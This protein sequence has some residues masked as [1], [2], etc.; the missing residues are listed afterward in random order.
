MAKTR[1]RHKPLTGQNQVSVKKKH[2]LLISILEI[3]HNADISKKTMPMSMLGH[4]KED[5]CV[6]KSPWNDSYI[7]IGPLWSG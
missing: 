7:I 3:V 2:S 1:L 4:F 6:C 5:N